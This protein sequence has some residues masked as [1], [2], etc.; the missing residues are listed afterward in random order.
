MRGCG[1]RRI[2][3]RAFTLI[4]LLVVVAII[5]LLIS[6]LLPSLQQAKEQAK[7]VK[8]GAHLRAVGLGVANCTTD[9]NGYGPSWDDGEL[10]PGGGHNRYMLTW[11]DVL[12]DRNYTGDWRVGHCPSDERP[13]E[14][15]AVRG[16][17]W[18]FWFV[19]EF[20]V[21]EEL[22]AGVRTSYAINAIM[23]WNW[24]AD[25]YS[26]SARQ[27]YAI[28]GWWT[29]FGSLNAMWL[30]APR[31]GRQ[32]GEPHQVPNWQGAQIGWRHGRN[33][34]AN[35]LY[36]D[37]HVS[38]LRPRVPRDINDLRNKTVDTT[39]SF[40]WLP[41]ERTTR[42]DFDSYRGEVLEWRRANRRPEFVAR[43][44]SGK[45]L[46]NDSVYEFD[47]PAEELHAAEMTIK[48]LWRK[49]PNDWR[50]ARR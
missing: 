5:A 45:K 36:R 33:L 49:L 25:K 32:L 34:G 43:S 3:A 1:A 35:T 7:T 46:S 10:G 38:V 21:G 47:Y 28:D 19:N 12:Y 39:K 40:T 11:V 18:N 26:D 30:M 29:W 31:L 23:Q 22:K 17:A 9:N 24:R 8:C 16:V 6:I 48:K 27:V 20:G 41:G 2:G 14:P 42:F 15:A 50:R 13:D 44:G 37:G 4:E